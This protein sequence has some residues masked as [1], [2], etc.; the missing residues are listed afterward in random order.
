MSVTASAP[1]KI[2]LFFTVG[3]LQDDGFHEVISVY[4]ALNLRETVKV[5]ASD[6]F[7]LTVSG[8][9]EG[10]PTDESNLAIRAA[11]FVSRSPLAIHID[12]RVPVAGG[13]G[14]GSADAAAV[15][16][17][18]SKLVGASYSIPET[19]QLGSDVPF[20]ILGGTAL[21]L[22]RGEILTP[23]ETTGE[24]HWVLVPASYGLNTPEVYRTL[25]DIR[26]MAEPKDP[27]PLIAALREGDA[28]KIA[29]LLH[30]D[31]QQA[32]L[33]LRPELQE[34]I[35][36]LEAAGALRAMVSGSGPTIL[37]LAENAEDASRIAAV[38]GGIATSGPSA[39]ATT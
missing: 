38:C 24:L 28:R 1:G 10:V 17:A 16:V 33:H 20:A 4:H 13:M 6:V 12:K 30:N 27:M 8:I 14:G 3:T 32:A 19:V 31:L 18:A 36:E 37:A 7:S 15:V 23:L 29:P 9:T 21:G 22:G 2:N 26:P 39:G 5:T 25:D 35:D 34:T 11:K